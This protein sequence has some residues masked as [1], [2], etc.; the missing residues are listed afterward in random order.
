MR[1][2]SHYRTKVN[3]FEKNY[4]FFLINLF[5]VLAGI[6]LVVVLGV[7]ALVILAVLGVV[8]LGVVVLVVR[9]AVVVV[10]VGADVLAGVA[11]STAATALSTEVPA[12]VGRV[13]AVRVC[14]V[15][16][17]VERLSPPILIRYLRL[18]FDKSIKASDAS[19]NF[20]LVVSPKAITSIVQ[21][22][23]SRKYVS[24]GM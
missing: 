16:V 6:R 11:A 23:A 5:N 10:G 18:S 15:R 19:F 3:G 21:P 14:I 8:V 20:V 1:I 2:H 9:A 12:M 24:K 22:F 13:D 7:V 4:V 17:P